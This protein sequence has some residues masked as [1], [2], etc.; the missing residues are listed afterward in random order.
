MMCYDEAYFNVALFF[1]GLAP[2]VK[3][4]FHVASLGFITRKYHDDLIYRTQKSPSLLGKLGLQAY[5]SLNTTVNWVGDSL[6]ENWNR[7]GIHT[8]YWVVNENDEIVK[9]RERSTC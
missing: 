3:I 4:D 6:I 7:R 5:S 9:L 2:F 1:L 8:C